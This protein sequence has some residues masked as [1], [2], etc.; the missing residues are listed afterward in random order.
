MRYEDGLIERKIPAKL[1]SSEE[2]MK[3]GEWLA[4]SGEAK[5]RGLRE[6]APA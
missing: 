6:L 3:L 5:K 4:P 2:Q 1:K